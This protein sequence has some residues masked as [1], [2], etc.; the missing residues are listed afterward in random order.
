MKYVKNTT[1][2]NLKKPSKNHPVYEDKSDSRRKV[3]IVV[4][5]PWTKHKNFNK[6]L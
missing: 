5:Q 4:R 2:Q 3:V 6:I 1:V